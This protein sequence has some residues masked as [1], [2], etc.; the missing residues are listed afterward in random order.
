[1]TLRFETGTIDLSHPALGTGVVFASDDFFAPKERLLQPSEPVFIPGKYDDH[2]KWMDGWESRRR[3]NA[4]HD[5]CI[6]K[7]GRPGAIAGLDIDTRHFTGNF[8][9]AASV[10]A[11]VSAQ[12]VPPIDAPWI[13]ILP[14]SA[15]SGNQRNLFAVEQAGPW[16][17]LKLN[18]Y[19]DGG[20][21][22]LRIY[23]RVRPRTEDLSGEIDLASALNGAR[24]IACNDEHF[25]K[26]AN[27]LWPS[28]AADMGEGW[29]TR[30]RRVPGHDW[31]IIELGGAGHVSKIV[32][33]TAHFKGNFPDQCSIQAAG[34]STLP[35]TALIAQ[36]MFW[37]LLLGEQKLA[38]DREHQYEAEILPHG[39]IK[40][41]RVNIIPD[42]GVSRLRLFGT[43]SKT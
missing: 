27:L 29:E 26:L 39:P 5:Y 20:V 9:P 41:V 37:P 14:V 2:G 18:I 32:I 19:P 28:R 22:R 21:A 30:R 34:P 7:L 40:F 6:I 23:G 3:R 25:G 35:D 38:M 11:C 31:G 43:L 8:P 13:D 36:S 1:M 12:D 42:G 24:P 15:L 10:Q 17:H 16:T 33:D 4:G